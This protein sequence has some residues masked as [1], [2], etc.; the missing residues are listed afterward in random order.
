[1]ALE[2]DS[3][4]NV[5]RTAKRP[6]D[7]DLRS[8]CIPPTV[9]L[10]EFP[11]RI[12]FLTALEQLHIGANRLTAI[13]ESISKLEHLTSF[14]VVC[15]E[16]SEIP[17]SI[18][19][20]KNLRVLNL[21]GNKISHI[22]ESITGLT[23]LC[24]LDLSSN[25][26]SLIPLGIASILNLMTFGF[27]DNPLSEPVI[28]FLQCLNFPKR[29]LSFES[30]SA[31]RLEVYLESFLQPRG[32]CITNSKMYELPLALCQKNR[33]GKKGNLDDLKTLKL[34]DCSMVCIPDIFL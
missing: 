28:K 15:N 31:S 3:M 25:K 2:H 19:S 6:S 20:N 11:D 34:T 33:K 4:H 5:R 23:N 17:S 16:L 18:A 13:P 10:S 12:S 1:M 7:G 26:I 8:L 27:Q 9:R 21:R 14:S 22:P 29:Q 30:I 24:S 32:V